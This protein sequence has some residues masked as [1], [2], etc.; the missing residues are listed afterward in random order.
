MNP[1]ACKHVKR[2]RD[3]RRFWYMIGAL[4]LALAGATGCSEPESQEKDGNIGLARQQL[5]GTGTLSVALPID[6]VVTDVALASTGHVR[7]ADRSKVLADAGPARLTSTGTGETNIGADAVVRD[8]ASVGNVFL[9]ERAR[10]EGNV[11]T[12]GTIGT[13]NGVVVTGTRTEHAT[14]T[15]FLWS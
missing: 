4:I 10:V 5:S 6:V 2:T 9:R 1:K 13:Q 15:P 8:I 11:L 12:Q 14:L 7:V 3:P